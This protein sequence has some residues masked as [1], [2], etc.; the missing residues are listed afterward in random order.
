MAPKDARTHYNLACA[1]ARQGKQDEALA[2]LEKAVSLG[3]AADE[4]IRTD[5]DLESLHGDKQFDAVVEK[6]KAQR[7]AFLKGTYDKPQGLRTG[8]SI[9]VGLSPFAPRKPRSFAER[10]ATL[11]SAPVLSGVKTVER[12]PEGGLRYHLRMPLD[13]SKAKPVR[14]IVWLHPSGGSGNTMVESL[15]ERFARNGYAL[16]LPNEKAW[17]GWSGEDAGRLMDKS[18][19]DA[20][21]V[22][23]INAEK[24]ILMGFSAGGQMALSI[25]VHDPS[26]LGG[27]ILDAAY[28]ITQEMDPTTRRLKQPLLNPPDKPAVKSVPIYSAVGGADPGAA[29]WRKA[30]PDWRKAGVP[31]TLKVVE[32]KRHQWLFDAAEADGLEKW[33]KELTR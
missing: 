5:P 27:L 13:A 4:H 19:P 16:L 33:L 22:E 9:S 1:Q 18:L 12:Q 3:F 2:S 30:E 15:A 10:K 6:A 24:P 25:W 31:L 21:K 26:K 20:A 11:I 29:L 14:L 8:E 28:P 32:G 23:G 7:A 17:F